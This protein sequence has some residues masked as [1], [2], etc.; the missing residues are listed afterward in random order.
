[1]ERL[2]LVVISQTSEG[3]V[4]INLP[5]SPRAKPF[6]PRPAGERDLPTLI[7]GGGDKCSIMFHSVP[8]VA[9]NCFG[10]SRPRRILSPRPATLN[11]I[12]ADVWY[13]SSIITGVIRC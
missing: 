5:T 6:K 12:I 3:Q 4:P 13:L 1:M 7:G 11:G 10:T 2:S 9:E 8:S